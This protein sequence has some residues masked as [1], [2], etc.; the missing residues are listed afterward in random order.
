M[1]KQYLSIP[2]SDPNYPKAYWEFNKVR[3]NEKA[4]W[5]RLKSNFGITKEDYE[6]LFEAQ[7]GVCAS[8][9]KSEPNG[10]RLAVDHDHDTDKIR[11]LLCTNCNTG[12][13]LLGD[14]LDGLRKAE[15]YLENAP[16]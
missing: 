10:R 11:G 1:T 3:L 9:G 5:R 4:G 7:H 12:I 13:G 6:T 14:T 16:N 8:C 2:R 15:K